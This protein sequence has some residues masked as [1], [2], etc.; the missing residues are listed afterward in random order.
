MAITNKW[1]NHGGGVV[2]GNEWSRRV[3]TR[4][5]EHKHCIL[6]VELFP[7][8]TLYNHSHTAIGLSELDS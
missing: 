3:K 5:A 6:V 7:T 1:N 4:V 2:E 8:E